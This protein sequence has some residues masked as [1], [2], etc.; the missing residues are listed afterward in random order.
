MIIIFVLMII[1][2]ALTNKIDKH[3]GAIATAFGIFACADYFYRGDEFS[4]E[5]AKNYLILV[6]ILEIA[7]GIVCSVKDDGALPL[8]IEPIIFIVM[9]FVLKRD[10]VFYIKNDSK[11]ILSLLVFFAPLI[12]FYLVLL[13][14]S[15]PSDKEYI[16]K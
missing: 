4:K 12:F 1:A 3:I 10:A 5:F 8:V 6:S 15:K 14:K 13:L 9:F 7:R 11:A 16:F 2:L